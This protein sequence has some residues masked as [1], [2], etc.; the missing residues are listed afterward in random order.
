MTWKNS[1]FRGGVQ[2]PF[3]PRYKKKQWFQAPAMGVHRRRARGAADQIT[4]HYTSAAPG[5]TT[6]IRL[7][8]LVVLLLIVS[9][10]TS[11]DGKIVLR[12]ENT[13]VSIMTCC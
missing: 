7:R 1:C 11:L 12:R 8:T 2:L 6:G 9:E 10:L 3:L 5:T 4:L 13:S